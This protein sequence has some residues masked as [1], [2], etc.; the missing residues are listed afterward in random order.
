M[1][2]EACAAED[3]FSLGLLL[4]PHYTRPQEFEGAAIPEVLTGGDH[5]K[6][7]K[8]RRGEAERRTRERRPDLWVAYQRK[9]PQKGPDSKG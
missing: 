3:S 2:N 8:W 5:A 1:G 6:V 7:A 4:F 9:G